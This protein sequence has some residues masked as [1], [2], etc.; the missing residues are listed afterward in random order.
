MSEDDGA[1]FAAKSHGYGA[2]FPIAWQGWFVLIGYVAI[3][4][5]AGLLIEWDA[6]VGTPVGIAIF[7][8]ATMALTFIAK[9]KTRGGWKWRWGKKD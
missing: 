9:A 4:L 1:W 3:M 2:G 7:F 6:E 5:A 8:I